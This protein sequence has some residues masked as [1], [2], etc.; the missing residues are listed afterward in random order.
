MCSTRSSR[1]RRAAR[2]VAA[3]VSLGCEKNTVD[4]ERLLAQLVQ[5]GFLLAER[6]EEA[7]VCLVN[8]CGF[9]AAAR[10][11]T[12]ARLAELAAARARGRPRVL[13]ALGCLVERAGQ[14]PEHAAF[15]RD[16]D[17]R[18]GFGDYL[19]LADRC[20]ELLGL[21]PPPEA[22]PDGVASL[23]PAFHRLP[24][25]LTGSPHVAALKISEGCSHGC[26]FCSIP[27]IR[28]P[29]VS[30]PLEDLI[31]E[32][33]DLVRS[34]AREVMLIGQDTASYGLDLYGRRRI[35]DLI[36]A[37]S[38]A[39]PDPL[40]FRL[41]YAHP[42]HV[43]T[44][45][46]DALD[47]DPRWAPYLD[48]PLQHITTPMLRRMGRGMD[49]P[50]TRTLLN[51]LA[52]RARPP[53]LRSTFI[54]GHPGETEADFEEL[55]AFLR[56]GRI[57]HAGVFVYSP[58]PGTPSA[59][60]SDPVPPAVAEDR[61]ARL[62]EAQQEASARILD[63]WIGRTESL[64]LDQPVPGRPRGAWIAR[65]A[66]QAIEVDGVC[67]IKAPRGARWNPGDVVQAHIIGRDIYDLIADPEPRPTAPVQSGGSSGR[68]TRDRRSGAS[69]R[70]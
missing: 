22:P 11:E 36:R 38:D 20:L 1:P 69:R 46:L 44:A 67:R 59:T 55:L 61:R 39:L 29:Q 52:A 54:V 31:A 15:L 51:A 13:V 34:G 40:W 17:A 32:A 53:C 37:L 48:L 62:M 33:R 5:R 45:L 41:M 28:G 3:L 30:R 24:R 19:R 35:A 58:E 2:P 66:G 50:A 26:R 47:A 56:E 7:D 12:A 60:Q 43:T 25:L 23:D 57:L 4:S 16:A 14:I 63:T 27:Q 64:M 65:H 8:T 9:I 68:G 42:R 10:E 18:L 49:G 70:S 21:A 6:P